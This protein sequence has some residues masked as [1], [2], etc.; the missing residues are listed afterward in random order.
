[1]THRTRR[2]QRL[3]TRQPFLETFA[4][5]VLEI[6]VQGIRRRDGEI[7]KMVLVAWDVDLA[8]L[9]NAQRIGQGIRNLAKYPAHLGRTLQIELIAVVTEPIAIVHRFSRADAQQDVVGMMIALRE[10]MNVVGGHKRH[11]EV[12]CDRHQPLLTTSCSSMP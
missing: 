1:M 4:D 12:A 2:A 8:S 3:Q 9:G 7:R 11:V 5:D 10:V 6:I